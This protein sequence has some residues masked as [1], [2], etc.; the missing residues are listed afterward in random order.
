MPPPVVSGA[1]GQSEAEFNGA[2]ETEAFGDRYLHWSSHTLGAR[3]WKPD[4]T[5]LI[6]FHC[7]NPSN[8]RA[9]SPATHR[10]RMGRCGSRIRPLPP[11]RTAGCCTP[12]LR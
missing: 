8:Q 3:N 1:N 10:S 7:H 4:Y 6:R 5:N 11:A 12:P 9:K 2:I